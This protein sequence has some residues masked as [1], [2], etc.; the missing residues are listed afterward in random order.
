MSIGSLHG[1]V[2]WG[3]VAVA[4]GIGL[5]MLMWPMINV[6]ETGRTPQ[7]PD[8]VP[9]VYPGDKAAVFDAALHA[10]SRLPRWTLIDYDEGR[11][12]IRAEAVT[13]VLRFVDDVHVRLE[14]R[15]DGVTVHVRSASRVGKGDFGQNARNI[16]SF[17]SELDRQLTVEALH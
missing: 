16:R 7:Y 2:I 13:R 15:P 9:R 6:V 5:S 11:G 3:S 8:I 17:F 14:E 4:L 1:G 12:E 10:V